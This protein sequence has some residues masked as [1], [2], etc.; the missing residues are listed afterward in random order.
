MTRVE[1]AADI[2]SSK[3][4]VGIIGDEKTKKSTMAAMRHATGYL[5]K[6]LA[7]RLRMKYTPTLSFYIDEGPEQSVKMMK[8]IDDVMTESRKDDDAED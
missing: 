5:Q 3:V 1:M 2:R 4:H 8:L 6:E 7:S